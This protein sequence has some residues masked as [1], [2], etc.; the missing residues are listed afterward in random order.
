L[1]VHQWPVLVIHTAPALAVK[2][3]GLA[4]K[5][6]HTLRH[7]CAS[8]LLANNVHPK[9]VQERL[10]HARI[11]ITLQTYSHLLPTSQDRAVEVLSEAIAVV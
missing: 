10:G 8:L 3:A 7:T 4:H 9:I 2:R 6:F 11:E 1:W 5:K